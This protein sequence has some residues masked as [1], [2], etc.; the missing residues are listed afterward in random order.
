MLANGL[1]IKHEILSG[2][3]DHCLGL[4]FEDWKNKEPKLQEEFW[5]NAVRHNAERSSVFPLYDLNHLIED[6]PNK[7][8]G[9]GGSE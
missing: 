6:L 1:E 4:V 9:K 7:P 5:I 8:T 2:E 3:A